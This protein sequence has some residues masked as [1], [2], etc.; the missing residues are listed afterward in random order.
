MFIYTCVP[1]FHFQ[2]PIK[3]LMCPKNLS[4]GSENTVFIIN[5]IILKYFIITSLYNYIFL[6]YYIGIV[7]HYSVNIILATPIYM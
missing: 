2:N 6:K 7:I 4:R 5:I 1:Y 3:F